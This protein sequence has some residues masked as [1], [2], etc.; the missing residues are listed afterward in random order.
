MPIT[1]TAEESPIGVSV[2][3]DITHESF[4]AGIVLSIEEKNRKI[5]DF[6]SG[7]G[8]KDEVSYG[9]KKI[10]WFIQNH[11]F[12]YVEFLKGEGARV[13]TDIGKRKNIK[14]L[15]YEKCY[16]RVDLIK[17]ARYEHYLMKLVGFTEDNS[18]LVKYALW[19]NTYNNH[20]HLEIIQLRG[21]IL[22]GMKIC[23][24]KGTYTFVFISSIFSLRLTNKH[25]FVNRMCD[26][27]CR[28]LLK[29]GP[30]EMMIT[31]QQAKN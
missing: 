4:V 11:I 1:E 22:V 31:Q 17:R 8:W 23:V 3:S 2:F 28:I 24:C 14:N 21:R 26:N 30:P 7:W 27:E 10:R 19:W 15:V 9:F 25:T 12:K 5:E 20:F 16:E 13:V 18:S 6:Y 29:S